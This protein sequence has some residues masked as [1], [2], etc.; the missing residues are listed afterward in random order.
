MECLLLKGCHGQDTAD[1]TGL[2]TEQ[3][4]SKTCLRDG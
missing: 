2:H 3:H 1:D 4:A